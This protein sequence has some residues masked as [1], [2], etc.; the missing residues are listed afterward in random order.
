V[1]WG[2]PPHES[3][4]VPK[5]NV[6]IDIELFGSFNGCGIIKVIVR[7]FGYN[8]IELPVDADDVGAIIWHCAAPHEWRGANLVTVNA[9][10]SR[11]TLQPLA[12]N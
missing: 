6:V 4:T 12:I 3:V 9:A 5:L 11:K 8:G 1:A 2:K 10:T 7:E